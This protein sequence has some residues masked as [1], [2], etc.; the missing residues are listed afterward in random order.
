LSPAPDGPENQTVMTR[1]L[2][3]CTGVVAVV[4]ACQAEFSK[5]S[6]VNRARAAIMR[7]D[8]YRSADEI[9]FEPRL[10]EAETAVSEIPSLFDGLDEAHL[11]LCIATEKSIRS[12]LHLRS[13]LEDIAVRRVRME[14]GE[15]SALGLEAAEN[16]GGP[17]AHEKE[18]KERAL[19]ERAYG[20]SK[21][22]RDKIA[23]VIEDARNSETGILQ[24]EKDFSD[25]MAEH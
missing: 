25:C 22:Q 15:A 21:S 20:V 4:W 14:Y 8:E 11:G 13:T 24:E 12:A 7:M 19:F 5:H 10:R 18:R 16:D 17:E 2:L 6:A 9:L 3:V 1:A 23:R